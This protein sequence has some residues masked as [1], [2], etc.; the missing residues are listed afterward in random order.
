MPPILASFLTVG[1]IAFLF[2]RDFR[3][4]PDVTGALWL[5]TLWL[6]IITSRSVTAWL[7]LCGVPVGGSLEDGSPA[8]ATV[9]GA[10]IVAGV[11]VLKSRRIRLGEI[12]RNNRLLTAFLIYCFVAILW[13]DF[14]LVSLKRW[15]KILGHP[16]MTLVLFTEPDPEEALTRLMKRCAY[17]LVPISILFIKYYPGLGRGFD[18][19]S[20]IGLNT[21]ITTNKNDLGCDCLILGFFFFWQLLKTWQREDGVARRNEL[22]LCAAFLGMIGWLLKMAQSSTS[23]VSLLA[24]IGVVIFLGLRFINRRRIGVYVVIGIV[25]ILCAEA[26]FG[27]FDHTLQLLGKDPTLTDRTLVWHSV[28]QVKINPIFGAGFEDFWMGDRLQR[29]W[30]VYWWHPVQAHNGYLETYLNLGLVGLALMLGLILSTFRKGC[31]MLLENFEWG[32]Y[33]LGFLAAFVL[34]NWTEAAIKALHPVWF[35]FYI[36]AMDYPKPP[37]EVLEASVADGQSED[38]EDAAYVE[39]T[40]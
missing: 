35:V 6:L 16:I 14:P 17:V 32:R 38:T 31:R 2:R 18:P 1:F 8:D 20:G 7:N 10:I 4:K 19:W 12:V 39:T 37:A 26:T 23:T 5:P 13:S 28:L 3:E 29:L 30:D 15:I 21:G 27:I 9:Y 11:Y 34:Y 33:R 24:A 22:I 40:V 36:I 25:A